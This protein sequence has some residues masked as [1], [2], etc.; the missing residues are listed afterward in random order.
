[1]IRADEKTGVGYGYSELR[2]RARGHR[3]QRSHIER[4]E[5]PGFED[6]WYKDYYYKQWSSLTSKFIV[7]FIDG[8]F[9]SMN[10]FDLSH[11][12]GV[13]D[14]WMQ[15]SLVDNEAVAQSECTMQNGV[16]T[17]VEIDVPSGRLICDDSLRDAEGF[18]WEDDDKASYNTTLG[19]AQVVEELATRGLFFAPCGN[20][21]PGM[22]EIAPGKYAVA[23]AAYNESD[24][25][26][27]DETLPLSLGG[28]Q[29]DS[30]CTDL[31]AASMADYDNFLARGGK[32]I[33]ED[34]Q[35]STRWV[36]D[37]PAGRYRMTFHG[38]EKGFDR[39]ADEV[40]FAQI[41]RIGDC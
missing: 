4:V 41:E 22:W 37:V 17:V 39:D 38:G 5:A 36:M 11:S 27:E 33:E 32:P 9:I 23:S 19:Q 15:W 40:I 24:D 28:K 6:G 2:V 13:C 8:E 35:Y 7:H 31:W 18:D 30:F 26:S 20:S 29:I 3:V 12:C 21:C 1:M 10:S 14:E 16:T 25:E 34:D